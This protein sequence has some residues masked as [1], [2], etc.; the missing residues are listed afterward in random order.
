MS[1]SEADRVRHIRET[2]TRGN[3]V[4]QQLEWNPSTK[5]IQ[6]VSHSDPDRSTLEI[7]PSDMEHFGP[8][9]KTAIVTTYAETL[10]KKIVQ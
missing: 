1:I 9:R 2:R 7:T 8:L 6:A 4:G 5:R 3:R 10:K